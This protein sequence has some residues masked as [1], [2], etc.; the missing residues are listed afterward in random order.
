[1]K[2][3]EGIFKAYDVRGLTP[4]EL[5]PKVATAIGRAF[6]DYLGE[7]PVA[8]GRDM[9][10][11]SGELADAIIAGL[12]KQGREVIDIGMVTS[13]MIYF[14]VGEYGL[15]GGAMVTA[16]HNP[17]QYNGIKFTGEGVRPIGVESGLADIKRA[18]LEDDFKPVKQK[19]RVLDKNILGEWI[20]HALRFGS[21]ELGSLRVGIDTG[22]GMAGIVLPRLQELTSLDI[23]SLFV[24]LDGT[25]PNHPANP[26]DPANLVDIITLVKR[27]GLDCGIAFDGDGDRAFFIDEK[28]EIVTG[29]QIGALLAS[30]FL[31]EN[32]GSTILHNAICSRIV[33]ETIEK[34]G[35]K[36]IRTRVGHS[37]IKAK[38][39]EHK[40][41]F[42]CEHS[43]HFYYRDNFNADSG[44][45]TVIMT[46]SIL[47]E[48][49][50]PLSELVAPYRKYVNSGEINS[51][52][53]NPSEVIKKLKAHYSDGVA[54]TLDGLTVWY[55]DWWFNVRP[56]NTEPVVRLNVETKT[57]KDNQAK[58]D[59]LLAIIRS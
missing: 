51:R 46:L 36:A 13:D 54:D 31:R 3:D 18:V 24:D 11:D 12:I 5:S 45:I 15:A 58:V 7:G 40:A 8:V 48:A 10:P 57:K 27:E 50:K 43:G 2:F 28:G 20:N 1:M 35:G 37:Y 33:P 59:Q 6:G 19:G 39:R 34:L 26:L 29:S 42:A 9:R 25:F 56:S 52:V 44:L 53:A 16:S 32:P 55:D 23:R 47:S 4:E 30:T 49:G 38:M 41:I 14:A 21:T 17:G 22:N